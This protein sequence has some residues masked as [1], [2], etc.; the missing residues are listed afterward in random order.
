[1]TRSL[2]LELTCVSLS[3]AYNQWDSHKRCDHRHIFLKRDDSG[4]HQNRWSR[5]QKKSLRVPRSFMS[6]WWLSDHLSSSIRTRST[7]LIMMPSTYNSKGVTALPARWRK[8]VESLGLEE[9]ELRNCS[10]EFGKPSQ[11]GSFEAIKGF[12]KMTDDMRWELT[13]VLKH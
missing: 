1:M 3:Q 11:R 13:L 7:P 5:D 12:A 6:K 2:I 4:R 9:F 10:T 8:Q